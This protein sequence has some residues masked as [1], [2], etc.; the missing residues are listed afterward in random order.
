MSGSGTV[1]RIALPLT[2]YGL[3]HAAVDAACAALLMGAVQAGRLAPGD[4]LAIFLVYNVVAFALQPLAGLLVDRGW[5][6][7]GAA[8]AGAFLTAA[9]VPLS[10]APGLVAAA[11]VLAGVGNAVFH[12][13]GGVASLR[14]TPGRASAPGI[15]V[16]PGAA[17]LAAGALLGKSGGP[18]WVAAAALVVLGVALAP[19][20][21][22]ATPLRLRGGRPSA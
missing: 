7:R 22:P 14:M 13:G 18:L 20:G 16:A 3:A 15:Y 21:D 4:A 1:R 19:R 17:G 6:P 12:V 11:V 5:S 10:F 9:A 2:L 8:V